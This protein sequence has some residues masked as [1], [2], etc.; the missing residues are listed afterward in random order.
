MGMVAFLARLPKTLLTRNPLL[1]K[2]DSSNSEYRLLLVWSHIATRGS[3]PAEI[4]E[5]LIRT[6]LDSQA[7]RLLR[8]RYLG[9]LVDT[10]DPGG[11]VQAQATHHGLG[12][13]VLEDDWKCVVSCL[14]DPW[15]CGYAMVER[16]LLSCWQRYLLD[17]Q[18]NDL[19]RGGYYVLW[20]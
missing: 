2:H 15:C 12:S 6:V 19:V 17:C 20:R 7:G 10:G 14:H 13:F 9:D 3:R 8:L 16:L 5:P 4:E 18:S 1:G 11:V